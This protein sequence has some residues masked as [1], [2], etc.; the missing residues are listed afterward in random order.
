MAYEVPALGTAGQVYTAAAHN[1]IVN[2]VLFFKSPPGVF[3]VQTNLQTIARNT[4]TA[5][6]FD[7]A[8]RYD[9]DAMHNPSSNNTRITIK[10]AGVYLIIGQ[11]VWATI[12]NLGGLQSFLRLNGSTSPIAHANLADLGGQG[13]QVSVTRDFAVNDYIEL[14]GAHN[15]SPGALNTAPTA[16]LNVGAM[17]FSAQWLGS[18]T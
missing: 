1:I 13:W 10:T 2:D 4:T 18:T 3:C 5:A 15:N 17:Q 12:P 9:T 11:W 14:W 7:G 6:I 16:G 8:D